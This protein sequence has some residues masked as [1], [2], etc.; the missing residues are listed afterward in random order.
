MPRDYVAVTTTDRGWR[1]FWP[2]QVSARGSAGESRAR[3]ARTIARVLTS[4]PGT[5]DPLRIVIAAA[6]SLTRLVMARQAARKCL[7][8]RAT[9]A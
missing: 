4:A 6:A 2:G 3:R 5:L 1:E 9:L 7:A 8:I